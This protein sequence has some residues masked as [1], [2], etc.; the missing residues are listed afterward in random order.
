MTLT[1]QIPD[2]LANSIDHLEPAEWAEV[3]YCGLQR[4]QEKAAT[5]HPQISG[6]DEAMAF[7]ATLPTPSDVMALRP[8][9]ELSLRTKELLAKNKLNRLSGSDAAEWEE[10][11]RVEHFVRMAKARAAVLLQNDGEK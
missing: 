8:S 2:E 5:H 7:L 6:L 4:R 9:M 1:L 11:T 10:I 3:L